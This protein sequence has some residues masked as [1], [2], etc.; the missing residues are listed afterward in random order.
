MVNAMSGWIGLAVLAMI[1]IAIVGV[2]VW[3][4][5]KH[6]PGTPHLHDASAP[7]LLDE[8]LRLGEAA[9]RAYRERL[10]QRDH[11]HV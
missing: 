2:V 10:E 4:T 8:R 9:M 7:R 6:R 11:A 5:T 1:S 3:A